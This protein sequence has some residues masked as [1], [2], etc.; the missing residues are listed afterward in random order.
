MNF[1]FRT[2]Q[3]D[4]HELRISLKPK[5]TESNYFLSGMLAEYKKHK[6]GNYVGW[7]KELSSCLQYLSAL[8]TNR[9]NLAKYY[10]VAN[11]EELLKANNWKPATLE[12]IEYLSTSTKKDF[13]LIDNNRFFDNNG[14]Y[15]YGYPP[16][17]RTTAIEALLNKGSIHFVH[18]FHPNFAKWI[19]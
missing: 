9:F 10:N 4:N 18:I 13:S 3:R 14:F 16:N 1:T 8:D 5:D 12:V 15:L 11:A 6:A 17:N 7:M 2:V 19:C